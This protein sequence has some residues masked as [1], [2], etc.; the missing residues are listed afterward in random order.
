MHL[1][2]NKW[3]YCRLKSQESL[4]K[5]NTKQFSEVVFIETQAKGLCVSLRSSSVIAS[6]K[7]ILI[8]NLLLELQPTIFV[9]T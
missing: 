4:H 7:I 9:A 3:N 6:G 8:N 2:N 1:C 5:E